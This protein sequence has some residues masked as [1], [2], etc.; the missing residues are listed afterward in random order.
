MPTCS[1]SFAGADI[2]EWL[3]ELPRSLPLDAFDD[4]LQL[5][6]LIQPKLERQMASSLRE[7][8]Q[9]SPVVVCRLDGRL[10]LV[11]GFKRLRAARSLKDFTHL[12]ARLLETDSQGAKAAIFQ[13]NRVAGKPVELEEA[14]IIHALVHQDGMKQAEV[15]KLFGRHKSWVNRRL[16]L[17]ERLCDGARE[18][19]RLGLLTPTQ[20]RHLTRLP[21]GNQTA[22]LAAVSQE[23]LTSRELSGVIDLLNERGTPEHA[24]AVLAKPREALR[25]TGDNSAPPWNPRLGSTGN[26]VAKDIARLSDGLAKMHAWLRADRRQELRK[27]D[28]KTLSAGFAKL[29]RDIQLALEAV[30]DFRKEM[31]LP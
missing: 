24:A 10:V 1:E 13:L 7:Y 4:H 14:W 22:V 25:K 9:I 11:D 27:S 2:N 30:I 18:S 26:R 29:E 3:G 5:Y 17:I 28:R 31:Q 12:N 21:R 15:A 8:G 20:A 23:S 16:A 19:L 6:R